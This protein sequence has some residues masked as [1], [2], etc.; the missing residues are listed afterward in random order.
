MDRLPAKGL[1]SD[2][3]GPE[4][5]GHRIGPAC[6]TCFCPGSRSDEVV[7][8]SGTTGPFADNPPGLSGETA[9]TGEGKHPRQIVIALPSLAFSSSHHAVLLIRGS[10][11]FSFVG[12]ERTAT[13]RE[14]PS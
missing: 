7:E 11:T 6:S 5:Y 14:G 1:S 13:R 10:G 8:T 3:R 4:G 12:L 2:G 9:A